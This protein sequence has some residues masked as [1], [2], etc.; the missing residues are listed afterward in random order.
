VGGWRGRR[1]TGGPAAKT[2]ALRNRFFDLQDLLQRIDIRID[3]HPPVDFDGGIISEM[4]RVLHR[5]RVNQL[6]GNVE[7]RQEPCDQYCLLSSGTGEKPYGHTLPPPL[8]PANSHLW[9]S[10]QTVFLMFMEVK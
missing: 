5:V 9:T 2:A 1:D 6:M 10:T 3:E 8:S 4:D 7:L